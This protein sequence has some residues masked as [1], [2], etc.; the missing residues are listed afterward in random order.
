MWSIEKKIKKGDFRGL[1]IDGF[2]VA[3]YVGGEEIGERGDGWESWHLCWGCERLLL[4]SLV[5]EIKDRLMCLCWFVF[6]L[7]LVVLVYTLDFGVN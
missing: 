3:K 4:A 1:T 6:W 5:F 2:G 7:M